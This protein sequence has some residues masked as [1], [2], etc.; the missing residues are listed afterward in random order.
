MVR[1]GKESFFWTSYSDLMTS[2]FFV[3]LVLF[4]VSF[5]MLN[6]KREEAEA[7]KVEAV[8]E[9]ERVQAALDKLEEIENATK[10]LDERH[11]TYNPRYKKHVLDVSVNFPVGS[12]YI[13]DIRPETR[14]ALI[15]AGESL[16]ATIRRM[17][18][19][20]DV[21]YLV[22]IEGQASK[23]GYAKNN[24]LSYARAL[25]LRDFWKFQGVNLSEDCEVIVGG[26]GEGGEMREGNERKNQRFLVHIVPKTGMVESVM[27][28]KSL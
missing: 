14:V 24:E 26:S 10:A 17:R 20:F 5:Y 19:Q 7:E 25:A 13:T 11:F 4:A 28:E 22:V 3:M 2:L 16:R 12:A 27:G 6:K 15:R 1:R 9:Q 21:E 8:A 23:D 18:E